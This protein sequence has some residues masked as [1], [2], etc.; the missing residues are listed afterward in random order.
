MSV[1]RRSRCW[2][3]ATRD[4]LKSIQKSTVTQK[5]TKMCVFPERY[6]VVLKGSKTVGNS[7]APAPRSSEDA[8][9][10]LREYTSD[11]WS[12]IFFKS[13]RLQAALWKFTNNKCGFLYFQFTCNILRLVGNSLLESFA[14]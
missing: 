1:F 9:M 4:Y 13:L 14:I 10:R 11:E 7:L 2:N 12:S 8:H 5:A 6:T 3:E